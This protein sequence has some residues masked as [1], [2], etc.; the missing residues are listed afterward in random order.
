LSQQAIQFAGRAGRF[1]AREGIDVEVE[2]ALLSDQ[3]VAYVQRL[4]D[5][6]RGQDR[7]AISLGRLR[8]LFSQLDTNGDGNAAAAEV[9]ERFADQFAALLSRADGN[10]DKQ[11][12]EQEFKKF[13]ARL[14]A[15]EANRPPLAETTQRAR[16]VIRRSDRDG[17]GLLQPD[18]TPR[19]MAERFDRLDQNSD[20]Q[21]DRAEVGRAVEILKTLRNSAEFPRNSAPAQKSDSKNSAQ[22]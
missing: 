9:P 7:M 8:I 22:N 17:D 5:S 2:L 3:Q 15:L 13:A 12:S 1:A 19:R 10:Q 18:E 20:G 21:L 6:L 16:Q 14:D 4:R 11:L